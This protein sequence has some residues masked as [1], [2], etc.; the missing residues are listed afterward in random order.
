MN[1]VNEDFQLEFHGN[2]V[3]IISSISASEQMVDAVQMRVI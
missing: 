2:T 1:Q 3:V